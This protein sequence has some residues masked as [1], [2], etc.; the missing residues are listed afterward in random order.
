VSG[1]VYQ[2]DPH[3]LPDSE[4]QA[5]ELALLVPGNHGRLLDQRRTPV[6][7]VGL[8]PASAMFELTVDAFE[9][10]GA[11]WRLPAEDV[12]RFQFTHD[13]ARA[14]PQAV[15]ELAATVARL[16]RADPIGCDPQARGDTEKRLHAAAAAAASWLAQASAPAVDVQ[17]AIA[18]RAG[19]P[20]LFELLER[21][22][23]ELGG[24]PLVELDRVFCA[25]LV[26]NPRSG[27][28]VKGHAIVLAQLGL[29]PYAGN[30]VRDP[31]TLSGA[32]APAERA[33]HL[34][35]RLAFTRALWAHLGFQELT[36]FRGMAAEA[37][38]PPRPAQ[39]LVSVTLSREVAEAHFAGVAATR[40]A[41]MWRWVVPVE[42]VLLTFLETA[43]MSARFAEAEVL[44]LHSA[45]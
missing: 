15:A 17:G 26:S 12:A 41:A 4:F 14:D 13:A 30:V 27:E 36:V 9:D 37:Q 42:Q 38:A 18:A 32:W 5:G 29:V 25:T 43:A 8:D 45:G 1:D 23:C 21:Y 20:R 11:H 28:V 44:L 2:S 31:A 6:T 22:L 33:E 40:V 34:I 3:T 10:S 7:V 35:A 39:S 19:D 16:D 24:E